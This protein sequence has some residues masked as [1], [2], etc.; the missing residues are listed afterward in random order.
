MGAIRPLGLGEI[1]D[2]SIRI[3]MRRFKAMTLAVAV[4][5]GPLLLIGAFIQTSTQPEGLGFP[6]APLEP[7]E[8]LPFTGRDLAIFL[9]GTLVSLVISIIAGQI[10]TAATLHSASGAYF[11]EPADWRGSLRFAF[12]RMRS[13]LWLALLTTVFAL[14]GL[15]ACI[16]PGV[17]M[18]VAFSVAVP[19]LLIEGTVG[20]GAITRSQQLVSGRWWS[21]FGTLAVSQLLALVV[22]LPFSAVVGVAGALSAS[23]LVL[24]LLTGVVTVVTSVLT[25][26]FIAAVTWVIYVDLRVRKEGFDLELLGRQMGRNAPEGGFATVNLP[27]VGTPPPWGQSGPPAPWGGAPGAP[28]GPPAGPPHGSP[29]GWPPP[30]WSPPPGG[31]AAPDEWAPQPTQADPS[32]PPAAAPWALTSPATPPSDGPPTNRPTPAGPA[33]ANPSSTPTGERARRRPEPTPLPPRLP[34]PPPPLATPPPPV[35]A[36]DRF[37][38]SE[39]ARPDDR[40]P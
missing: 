34:G 3:Y 8:E 25:T 14:L 27:G 10:A 33:P 2:T 17:W 13:L 21:T 6:T 29:P 19:V 18:Y 31:P 22:A 7:G 1:I 23:G 16:G 9:A 36:P 30:S 32:Q 39:P 26:P 38:A 28:Y 12:K 4:A 24:G 11:G 37:P 40:E 15:A 20:M 35:G 5:A